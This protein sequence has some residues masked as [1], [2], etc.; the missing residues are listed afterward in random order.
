MFAGFNIACQGILQALGSGVKSLIISFIRL[1][2]AVFPLAYLFT[3]F[4]NA[5]DLIWLSIPAAEVIGTIVA[6]I[7]LKKSKKTI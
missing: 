4:E 7:F 2:A 5:E 1:I 3:F 6:V